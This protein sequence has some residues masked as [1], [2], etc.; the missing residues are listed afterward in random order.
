MKLLTRIVGNKAK[1]QAFIPMELTALLLSTTLVMIP[2]ARAL[3]YSLVPKVDNGGWIAQNPQQKRRVAI[4]IGNAAYS[5]ESALANPVNDANDMAATLEDLGFKVIKLL[6]GD[7]DR[8]EDK[9]EEFDDELKK[10]GIGVL[11]Y[12]GHGIQYQGEN[13]MIPVDARL[14][15]PPD[16]KREAIPVNKILDWMEYA[17]NDLNIVILDACRND[18]FTR[19]WRRDYRG[20]RP[21]LA[22]VPAGLAN[23]NAIP[24]SLIVYATSPGNYAADGKGRNGTFT[25]HLLQHIR[26]EGLDVEEML[27]RVRAGVKQETGEKQIPWSAS[28]ITTEFSFNPGSPAPLPPEPSPT[29]V[30]V[31]TPS[32]SPTPAAIVNPTPSSFDYSL[33]YAIDANSGAIGS[34]AITPDGRQLVSAG[35]RLKIWNLSTGRLERDLTGHSSPVRSVAI[36]PDGK[37]L[38]SGSWDKTIKI[39]NLSTGRLERTLNG[40]SESD[41]VDNV[42]IT[43]DGKQLVSNSNDKTIKIWNLSTGRLERTLTDGSLVISVA[44]TP[45]RNKL[46]TGSKDNTIKI[47]NLSTGRLE[48]TLIL[49]HGSYHDQVISV[50]ITPDGNQLVSGSYEGIIKIW[51]L[52]TGRL[53]RTLTGHSY[54]VN[55]LA[56]TEDGN[57]LVSGSGD[58]TIKIWNLST[59]RL[60][61]TLTGHVKNV[62][63]LAITGDGSTIVSG[64]ND[65]K[66][67]VW[68]L[69]N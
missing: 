62:R 13:Y 23:T 6:D 19:R 10:G 36:T 39:W 31:T 60:E 54:E 24:E 63:S 3:V 47:W 58:D 44:I 37:Q 55:S 41:V 9:L 52:S 16:L 12:A 68:R 17:Q 20:D 8:M 67:R 22:V 4:V 49:I 59:G 1:K 11:Y 33:Q 66:I 69:E 46:V 45:D 43:P 15:N 21:S 40:H 26:T 48:R 50:A 7:K 34:V 61:R 53:E 51:D 29:P 5:G 2:E 14:K 18:P 38:V 27:R 32:P 30:V 25:S 57:R 65:R 35:H 42:A 56:I 28:S 64:G